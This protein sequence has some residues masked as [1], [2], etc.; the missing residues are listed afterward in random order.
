[1][2]MTPKVLNS[3]ITKKACYYLFSLSNEQLLKIFTDNGV[4]YNG[5]NYRI[6]ADL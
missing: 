2:N 1:M 6:M 4:S 5:P 3:G